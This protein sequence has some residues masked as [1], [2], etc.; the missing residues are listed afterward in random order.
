MIYSK[1]KF[2]ILTKVKDPLP[3][4]K[5][6]NIIYKVPCT[7]GK[8]YISKTTRQLEICL[9]ECK[10]VCIKG[11]TDKSTIAKHDWTEDHPISW[12]DTR[13]LQYASQT[14]KLVIKE[15]ICI[16][17]IPESSHFNCYGGYDIPNCWI[18]TYRK[19]SSETHAGHT[20]PTT[21]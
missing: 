18:A 16:W 11:F 17:M 10:E 12:G 7:C 6:A 5:Q 2:T 8:V 15:E 14:M 4:E 9:K 19:L 1:V 13:I 3:M 20:Y 21:S